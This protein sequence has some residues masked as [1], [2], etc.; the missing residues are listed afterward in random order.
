M[1]GKIENKRNSTMGVCIKLE[2]EKAGLTQGQLGKL[3]GLD[4]EGVAEF[5]N[6][7]SLTPEVASFIL[8]KMGSGI[9]FVAPKQPYDEDT[10]RFIM[11]II[12]Q[13]SHIYKISLERAFMY[14]D[15]FKGIDYLARF[16]EIE[17]TLPDDEIVANV[18]Q[19]CANNGGQL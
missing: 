4:E 10:T 19:I 17:Q 3:I 12:Y 11:S 8:E 2:R 6:G 7:T 9:R 13:F 14:M 18:A 15:M 5:E 16:K 1:T